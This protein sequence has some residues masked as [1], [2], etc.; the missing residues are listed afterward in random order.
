MTTKTSI[1]DNIYDKCIKYF[2]KEDNQKKIQ[3][4]IINPLIIYF[5]QKI[6]I[7]LYIHIIIILMILITNIFILF[8]VVHI[9]LR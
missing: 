2:S 8:I 5:K 1:V 4:Y 7:Y 9:Y 6:N 3:E